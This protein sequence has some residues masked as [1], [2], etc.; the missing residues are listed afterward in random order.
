M[1]QVS[2]PIE[3]AIT[4]IDQAI[5]EVLQQVSEAATKKDLNTLLPLARKA[6][7]LAATQDRLRSLRSGSSASAPTPKT[8]GGGR[9]LVIKVSEG[10]IKQNLLTFTEHVRAGTIRDGDRLDIEA[11]PSGDR[12]QTELLASAHKLR[13]RG[14]IAKFYRD[15]GVLAG[16]F[17]VLSEI[18]PGQWQLKK[19]PIH[20]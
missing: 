14:R 8:S 16:D 17:V 20:T 19:Q 2:D 7:E 5:T 12:F 18:N 6:V 10:M 1:G 11:L 9:Q 3:Q 13:E 4:Q 15:A